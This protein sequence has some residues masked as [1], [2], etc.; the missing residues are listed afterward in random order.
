MLPPSKSP[1]TTK[2][3]C[4]QLVSKETILIKMAKGKNRFQVGT[5]LDIP[6]TLP[7]WQIFDRSPQLKVQLARAMA[8]SQTT[9]RE[10]KSAE[11][12]SI[13]AAATAFKSLDAPTIETMAHKDEKVICLY[14]DA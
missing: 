12:N 14:I 5:F 4:D 13:S 9:K 6:I 1:K 8:S 10:K 11:P 2:I 7:I 3:E